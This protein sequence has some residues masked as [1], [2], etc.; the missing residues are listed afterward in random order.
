RPMASR[1]GLTAAW[2]AA[3]AVVTAMTLSAC[4]PAV[5]P[6][7]EGLVRVTV[8]D[9]E[10]EDHV[11]FLEPALDDETRVLGLS[12]RTEIDPDGGMI[13]VF[14]RSAERSFVMRHCLIPIDIVYVD[15]TGRVVAEHAM[16]PEEPQ[17]E[18]E[19]D[20][21]Y[22]NRLKRYSSRFSVPLVL[23]FDGGTNERLGIDEGDVIQIDD[24]DGLRARAD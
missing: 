14:P 12:H 9:N 2:P 10:G 3:F 7:K 18:D 19:S 21:D 24:L 15:R 16:L 6:G 22:E 4:T 17:G 5:P 1:F 23:E 20:F 13:F 8:T 11:F